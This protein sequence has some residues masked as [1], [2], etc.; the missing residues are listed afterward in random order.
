M[1]SRGVLCTVLLV[2]RCTVL[3]VSVTVIGVRERKNAFGQKAKFAFEKRVRA[4]WE[5]SFL[6]MPRPFVPDFAL[7]IFLAEWYK[8]FV[9]ILFYLPHYLVQQFFW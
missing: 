2:V 5:P 3:L 1:Y 4:S 6:L 7:Y 8:N 9:G